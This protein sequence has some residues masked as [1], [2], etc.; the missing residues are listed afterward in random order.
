MG[1]GCSIGTRKMARISSDIKENA[2]Q[3]AVNWHFS[4][5]NIQA[6]NDSYAH[7]TPKDT[8]NL[9]FIY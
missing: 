4:L 9:D 5:E 2:L 6:A 3:H 1:L 7:F 8:E